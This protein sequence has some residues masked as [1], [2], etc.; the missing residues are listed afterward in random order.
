[1]P[2]QC[3]L[4]KH[5]V[6]RAAIQQPSARGAT[7]CEFQRRSI[8]SSRRIIFS[9]LSMENFAYDQ[10]MAV[11]LAIQVRKRVERASDIFSRDLALHKDLTLSLEM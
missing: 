8:R 2:N 10:K 4:F 1:M 6:E 11:G 3:A 5:R 7:A 9:R